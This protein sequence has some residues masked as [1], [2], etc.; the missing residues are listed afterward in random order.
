VDVVW[1]THYGSTAIAD[2]GVAF[3]AVG[4]L[5][6]AHGIEKNDTSAMR[7]AKG[8]GVHPAALAD[9]FGREIHSLRD[10]WRKAGAGTVIE[11]QLAVA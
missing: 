8:R 5:A 11:E 9:E 4:A 10:A 7:A 6:L 3:E 2:V 1:V